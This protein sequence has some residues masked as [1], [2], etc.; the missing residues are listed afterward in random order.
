MGK[1]CKGKMGSSGVNINL[2]YRGRL[3]GEGCIAT[4]PNYGPLATIGGHRHRPLCW[5]YLTS[6]IDISYSDIGLYHYRRV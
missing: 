5:L 1:M 4:E 3:G 2:L 6:D